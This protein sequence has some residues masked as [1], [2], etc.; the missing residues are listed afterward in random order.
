MKIIATIFSL[1]ISFSANAGWLDSFKE[2]ATL[3]LNQSEC[4]LGSARG[5][6]VDGR[7]IVSGVSVITVLKKIDKNRVVYESQYPENQSKFILN[8]SIK[9]GFVQGAVGS[10]RAIIWC[11]LN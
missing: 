5:E 11:K 3:I 2:P 7:F 10:G 9:D 8:I 6:M 4:Y 1:L